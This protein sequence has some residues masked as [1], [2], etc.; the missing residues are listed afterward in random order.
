MSWR[1]RE[2]L[3]PCWRAQ[4]APLGANNHTGKLN[5]IQSRA[6]KAANVG[7]ET[8]FAAAGSLAAVPKRTDLATAGFAIQEGREVDRY[9][10][11][12]PPRES[13]AL[14]PAAMKS[15]PCADFRGENALLAKAQSELR[16]WLGLAR[17]DQLRASSLA[18]TSSIWARLNKCETTLSSVSW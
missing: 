7:D 13:A 15:K 1:R 10:Q 12:G 11:S 18:G 9:L 8:H 4:F 14:A 3:R 6:E 16:Q 17:D 5:L 2:E